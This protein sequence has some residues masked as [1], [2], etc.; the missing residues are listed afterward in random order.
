MSDKPWVG[1]HLELRTANCVECARM[2]CVAS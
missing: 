2:G 1:D